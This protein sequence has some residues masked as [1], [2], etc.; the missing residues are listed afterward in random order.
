MLLFSFFRGSAIE[1]IT[2]TRHMHVAMQFS[3]PLRTIRF[4]SLKKVGK[5]NKDIK[6]C[7][8]QKSVIIFLLHL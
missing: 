1:K 4:S 6:A 2:G 5:K 7:H 8:M 3:S